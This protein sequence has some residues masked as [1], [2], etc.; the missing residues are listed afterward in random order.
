MEDLYKEFW[1]S[2][3]ARVPIFEAGEKVADFKA[4]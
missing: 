4:G 3:T 1:D 2:A